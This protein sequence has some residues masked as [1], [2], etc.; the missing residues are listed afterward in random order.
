[1]KDCINEMGIVCKD[2]LELNLSFIR[3]AFLLF[4]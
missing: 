4:I 3:L 1:M 2:V